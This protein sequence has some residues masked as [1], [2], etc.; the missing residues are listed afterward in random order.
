MTTEPR[1]ETP[2]RSAQ[3]ILM[4]GIFVLIAVVMPIILPD[5]FGDRS[6]EL[7]AI[8][9]QTGESAGDPSSVPSLTFTYTQFDQIKLGMSYDEVARILGGKGHE[10][11]VSYYGSIKLRRVAWENAQG[12]IIVIA[13]ANDA[14]A[15]RYQTG[16]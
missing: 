14:V 15:V 7:P 6:F 13:F 8:A 16:F 2:A 3:L 10:E 4:T 12:A 1:R 11:E 9:E 5:L